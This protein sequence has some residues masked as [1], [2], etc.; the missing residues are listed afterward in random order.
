MTEDNEQYAYF[1]ITDS[2][3]PAEITQ[4]LGVEPTKSWRKGDLHPKNRL[5][6]KFSR[7]SLAS[8]LDR[9]ADLED[10]IKDVLAQMDQKLETFQS[11]SREF[12]GCLQLVGYFRCQYPGLHFDRSTIEGLARYSL[13]V[14]FDFYYLYSDGREDT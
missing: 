9:S 11:V 3:D 4:R 12:G 14:D 5:E 7:W 10:H 6:R 1:T 13:T 8:R 2:F